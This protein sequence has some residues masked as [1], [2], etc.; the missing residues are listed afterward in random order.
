[1]KRTTLLCI[2]SVIA[3]ASVLGGCKAKVEGTISGA[4]STK[5]KAAQSPAEHGKY[6]VTLAGCNDCHTPMKMGPK[7]PEPDFSRMLSG[8]PSDM[9][10]PPPPKP[11]GPW[12]V[13]AAWT[14]TAWSTPMGL[15][16]SANITPDSATGIGKWDEATFM[17]AIRNGKHIGNGRPIMPPMPWQDFKQMTD[18]DLK[19]VYAFLRTVPAIHNQ[20]PDVV[21]APPPPGAPMG[22]MKKK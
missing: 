1:M 7:G 9:K 3:F 10:M 6:L 17:L 18:E 16:Y 20:V 11:E 8:H 15:A 2:V 4:D 12:M 5:S 19:A 21:M 22:D 13:M 14:L